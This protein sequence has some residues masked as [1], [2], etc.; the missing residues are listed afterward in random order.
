MILILLCFPGTTVCAFK[1]WFVGRVEDSN[2]VKPVYMRIDELGKVNAWVPPFLSSQEVHPLGNV[3][4][5]CQ[6]PLL[7]LLRV[8]KVTGEAIME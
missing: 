1:L 6:Y 2:R 8:T 3:D 5:G 4:V 7:L